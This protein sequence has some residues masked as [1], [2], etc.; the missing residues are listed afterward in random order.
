MSADSDSE[1]ED[2]EEEDS[3]DRLAG[4]SFPPERDRF[5][6]IDEDDDGSTVKLE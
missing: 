6:P 2:D 3:S 1:A 5:N 4:G